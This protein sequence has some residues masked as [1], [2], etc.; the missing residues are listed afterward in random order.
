MHVLPLHV[1]SFRSRRELGDH[2]SQRGG[3]HAAADAPTETQLPAAEW[4]PAQPAARSSAELVD[5]VASVLKQAGVP[6]GLE[7]EKL[8]EANLRLQEEVTRGRADLEDR[9]IET[10]RMREQIDT[11]ERTTTCQICFQRR[12]NIALHG[13]GH[14]MCSIC[15]AHV[16]RC[17][18]CRGEL[19]GSTQLRW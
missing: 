8:L 13:C 5:A 1:H 14:L 2:T 3:V 7:T 9:C 11:N 6:V 12:V 10:S 16:E 17:P 18:Y 4:Q 19:T 15:A